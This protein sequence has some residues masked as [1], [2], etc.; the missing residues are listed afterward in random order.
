M[1]SL[2]PQATSVGQP[3]RATSSGLSVWRDPLMQAVSQF[4]LVEGVLQQ[5]VL[6]AVAPRPGKLMFVKAAKF[7]E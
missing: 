7:H 1:A 4:H 6:A 2:V 3:I 5:F